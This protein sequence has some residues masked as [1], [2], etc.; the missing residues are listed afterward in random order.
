MLYTVTYTIEDAKG[1]KSRFQVHTESSLFNFVDDNEMALIEAYF[2]EIASRLAPL[3]RGAIV[4]LTI[5][6][7]VDV[8]T[9]KPTA[10]SDS[11]VEEI[12]QF[13]ITDRIRFTIPTFDHSQFPVS[14]VM[15]DLGD[16]STEM[17]Y[18]LMLIT[19]PSDAWDW[20]GEYGGLTDNRGQPQDTVWKSIRKGFKSSRK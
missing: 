4:G 15:R 19:Q 16:L 12:A 7:H 18:F 1:Q 14:G 3:I 20:E 6:A 8:G 10:S 11:D 5:T 2:V 17:E 9:I 13:L